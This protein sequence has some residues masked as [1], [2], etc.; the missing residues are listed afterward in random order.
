MTSEELMPT[1]WHLN[2]WWDW[3]MSEDEKKQIQ[4]L[5]KSCRSVCQQY[6]IWWYGNIFLLELL[7]HFEPRIYKDFELYQVFMHNFVLN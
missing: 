6:T 5:L 3:C 7:K 1:A 4:C 2:R